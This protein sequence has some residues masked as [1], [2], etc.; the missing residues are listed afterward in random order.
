MITF[1][2]DKSLAEQYRKNGFLKVP[3]IDKQQVE[4]LKIIFSTYCAENALSSQDFYYSLL[5]K[6]ERDNMD[7]KAKIEEILKESYN[8]YFH[9]FHSIAESFLM[10][11]P[12]NS[13][14]FLHQDWTYTR[15]NIN[16]CA[17]VWCPLQE[18]TRSNGA[19]FLIPG[20]H[21]VFQNFRSG[22]LPTARIEVDNTLEKYLSMVEVKLGEAVFFHPGLFHGSYPNFGNQNRIVAAS[23]ILPENTHISYFHADSDAFVSEFQLLENAYMGNIKNLTL[24]TIPTNGSFL[25]K[26][27]YKHFLPSSKLIIQ[28]LQFN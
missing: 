9:L 13:P 20:S 15:E 14:M 3:F 26:F 2:K 12:N 28:Q 8:R 24:G 4:L 17:T 7:L 25:S 22:N 11:P 10:K 18:V 19:L 23:L 16:E 5:N 21:R 27:E 1:F 6:G